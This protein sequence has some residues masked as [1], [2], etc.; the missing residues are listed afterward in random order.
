M[1]NVKRLVI[2][3]IIGTGISSIAVQLV[4]IREFMSQFHGNEITISLV[5]FTWLMLTGFGSLLAKLVRKPSVNF[6]SF[7]A[8]IIA[9]WP[10]AQLTIIRK[11]RETVF[12][13]G[14]SP[15]F[16]RIFFFIVVTTTLYCLLVGFILPY[17][18][19]VLNSDSSSYTSGELYITDNVGDIL[20]GVLFSFFFV[21][22]FKPFKTIALSS[23]LLIITVLLLIIIS[24]RYYFLAAS[25]FLILGF[26]YF[27]MS[28]EF[29]ILSL[30]G[31]YGDISRYE[32]SPYGRIVVSREGDQHTFWGSGIP[33]Y[34]DADIMNSEEKVHY[35]LSQL[36]SVSN[37]LLV[38][39][40]LGET[41]DEVLKYNPA[42]VD[43]IEPDPN[44]TEMA[45]ELGYL[46]KRPLLRVINQ[47]ARR[48]IKNTKVMYDAIIIDLP[49]PDT[50]Q[51]NRF[52]TSQFFGLAKERL[53]KKGILSFSL[54]YSP[55]YMSEIRRKKLSTIFNTVSL[56]FS[57][58]VILPG[59]KAYFL[60]SDQAISTEIPMN[61]R[62]R[63]IR[64]EYVEGFY[65]GD[66][67]R[68]RIRRLRESLDMGEYVNTDF[69]PRV[70]NIS[71]REWFYMHGSSPKAFLIIL[72]ILT[73]IYIIS[74]KKE[75]YILFSTGLV[76]M[77]AEMLVIFAFQILYGYVYLKVGAIITAS[78]VGLLPGAIIGN[79]QRDKNINNLMPAELAFLSMLI[80]FFIWEGF[81]QIDI[82]QI[83]FLSYCFIFSFFCGYQFPVAA[84]LI[85]EKR[86]PAAGCLAADL[87]GAAVGTLVTGTILIPLFGI[88]SAIIFLILVKLSSSIIIL[89][90]GRG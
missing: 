62:S 63:S 70:I 75:E 18:L 23:T 3:S 21:Y 47:D 85:G 8:L 31:Q 84:N 88:Q 59:G 24:R 49:E 27:S 79:L 43:Y 9:L 34:S 22:W 25:L 60:C 83:F 32:E 74:M 73:V 68:D 2:W 65:F 76:T 29:E 7:L 56:H 6:Y 86:R 87:Y 37:V 36:D 13:H 1:P 30:S 80:I 41:L 35:P 81:F 16:Y 90:S 78:L 33:L 72:S 5:L 53:N 14:V 4:T 26:Y 45:Q 10:L 66:V 46:E 52:F 51:L 50:F 55:N 19:R 11:V 61:L 82:K 12:I 39:G 64:T 69:E 48:F 28:T 20:G 67:T 89:L 54:D 44:L 38:S 42:R 57:N 40:G 58:V 17:A 15:G 71:L 77:G